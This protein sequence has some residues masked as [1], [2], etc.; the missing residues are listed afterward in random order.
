[1]TILQN[2]GPQQASSQG[3]QTPLPISWLGRADAPATLPASADIYRLSNT[4]LQ[5]LL[6]QIGYDQSRW[7]YTMIGTDNCL[8]RYQFTTQT[9]E[10]YGLLASGSNAAYGT[11]CI[12]Y[13]TCWRPITIKGSNSYSSYN[14]NVTSL[15]TF[16]ASIASQ[17]HLAYQIV[18][19]TY[20]SL[21]SNGSI[22]SSDAED[23]VAGMIYVG[24]TLGVGAQ[25]TYT[26]ASGT[27]AYAWR[28][29][30]VGKGV[31]SYNSGRYAIVFLSQ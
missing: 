7:D 4:Q 27:G 25:P 31:N 2:I 14:Y 11:D 26:N 20:N 1:M 19:D 9:L 13:K 8:G 28:Y 18:Y 16:L 5:N 15:S 6:A 21:V 30:G 10:K 24:W 17:E 29:S 23:I 22:K 3:I 12:N